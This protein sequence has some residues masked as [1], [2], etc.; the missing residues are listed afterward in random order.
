MFLKDIYLIWLL[1]K[2]K[3]SADKNPQK[4]ILMECQEYHEQ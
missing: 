3:I 4:Q 2:T 1:G